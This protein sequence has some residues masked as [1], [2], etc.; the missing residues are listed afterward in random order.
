MDALFKTVGTI[1]QGALKGLAVQAGPCALGCQ[2][3]M[4]NGMSG[5]FLEIA[6]DSL[7]ID[8][9]A[10]PSTS[11][12]ESGT[13]RAKRPACKRDSM[14]VGSSAR[15]P[16]VAVRA[17]AAR[18]VPWLP[19]PPPAGDIPTATQF[20]RKQNCTQSAASIDRSRSG[21]RPRRFFRGG[22]KGHCFPTTHRPNLVGHDSASLGGQNLACHPTPLWQTL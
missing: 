14:A 18:N 3:I 17:T 19:G 12:G 15:R 2:T 8:S 9:A 21:Y 11:R 20:R 16:C 5:V 10:L 6:S 7:S 4:V 1:S 13:R 22:N